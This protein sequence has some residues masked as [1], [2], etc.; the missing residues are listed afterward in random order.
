LLS[1]VT[2]A[3]RR[4]HT[5]A[6]QHGADLTAWFGHPDAADDALVKL[7]WEMTGYLVCVSAPSYRLSPL[8]EHA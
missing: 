6:V 4:L 5:L 3:A 8:T 1:R 2:D 7:S